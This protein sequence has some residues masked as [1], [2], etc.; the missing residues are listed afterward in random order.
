MTLR[1]DEMV[2][3]SR[4]GRLARGLAARHPRGFNAA[5]AV[6]IAAQLLAVLGVLGFGALVLA[7]LPGR[8]ALRG[9]GEMPQATTF[10]DAHDEHVF[11][12]FDERRIEVPLASVSP[13]LVAAV[14][15]IEDQRF[16]EHRGIDVVRITGAAR[17]SPTCARTARA[18][19]ASTITQQLARQSFLSATKTYTRKLQEMILA[20]RIERDYT[21]DQI[22]ELY[23]NKVYFGGRLPRRRGRLARLL[24]QAGEGPRR[25]RGRAARRPDPGAEQLYAPTV[26]PDAR[27]GAARPPCWRRCSTPG[28]ST[29]PRSSRARE[30]SSSCRTACAFEERS[31]STSRNRPAAS[32]SSA[33]A[34]IASI[35]GGLRVYTTIDSDMQ[36]AAEEAVGAPALESRRRQRVTAPAKPM[37]DPEPDGRGLLQGALVAL[38]PKTGGARDGRR[39]RLRREPLQP[40][41]AGPAAAG[42]GLQAVRVR[43]GA[44]AGP[45]ARLAPHRP[46]RARPRRRRSGCPTDAPLERRASMTMRHALRC[47]ATGRQCACC[48]DIGVQH[49][50]RYGEADLGVGA[51]PAVPSLA[52]GS[53]EVTLQA[54]TAAFGAFANGASSARADAG[55]R[56]EDARA[57]CSSRRR[58]TATQ[59]VSP[60]TA[61]LASMLADV[62]NGGTAV[63]RAALGFR[64]PAAGKTGTT[65]DYHDAWFVGFTP[66][67]LSPGCGW[68]STSR[69]RSCG[70]A[71]RATSRCPCGLRS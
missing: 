11:Q 35:R 69:R 62:V 18:Q 54:M 38:D 1:L 61:F 20:M 58:T 23:L 60:A 16:Y 52:L 6:A 24:R 33:S 5:L 4:A 53:G 37:S 25:G 8:D 46:R 65:N 70:G 66:N 3:R 36:K 19:G 41:R 15:A 14:I 67:A 44:R 28:R 22:L 43:R 17:S 12:I 10:F 50:V 57:T 51:M 49:A 45:H 59:A 63:A 32:S 55:P 31:A 2:A 64:L 9:L 47:R 40:R 26:Q 30:P 68:A 34:G 39:A 71:T 13:H 27:P 7:G 42:L 29:G 21:K 56:V 48:S